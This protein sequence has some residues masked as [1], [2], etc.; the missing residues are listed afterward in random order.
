MQSALGSAMLSFIAHRDHRLMRRINRWP[1][2]RWVRVWMLAATRCG[3]GGLCYAMGL[4]ILLIG[5]E[6]RFRAFGAAALA[7]GIGIT[8]FLRVKKAANRRRPS[9]FEPHSWSRLL[10]PDQFSFPSGHTI[11]A[12]SVAVS[13]S[14]FYPTLAVGL[15]F[16]AISVA[17]SRILLGMHFLSDVLAGAAIGA[18]LAYASVWA[19]RQV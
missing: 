5:G 15:L 12:F 13:L 18:S 7:A 8:L 16:C 4:L 10:P 14:L 6:Q 9:V 3:D 1:A 2:P 19:I 11:T 17:A